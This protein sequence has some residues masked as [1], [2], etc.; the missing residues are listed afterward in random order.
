[1]SL[2]RTA[3]SPSRT[4]TPLQ[5]EIDIRSVDNIEYVLNTPERKL[6]GRGRIFLTDLR[7][8]LVA[9]PPMEAFE[10]LSVPHTSLLSIKSEA[11]R[12]FNAPRIQLEIRPTPGGGLP[13]AGSTRAE[14]RCAKGDKEPFLRFAAALDKTRERAVNKSRANPE[15]DFD[16][17]A[18]GGPGPSGSSSTTTYVTA[19]VPSDAPPG[20]EP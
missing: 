13:E 15:D 4:P 17:P 18:Y 10:S 8:I 3:L 1:M 9:D 12:L 14:F 5:D 7:M 2:N 6:E 19:D 11:P 20:Y 16:L